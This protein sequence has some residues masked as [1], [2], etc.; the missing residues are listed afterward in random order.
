MSSPFCTIA[1]LLWE[2]GF[3]PLPVM[4]G[5]KIPG[6][7]QGGVWR[8]MRGWTRFCDEVL[9]LY[10]IS[11]WE[12]W[13][14]AGISI[15]H[16]T[17][18]GLDVDTDRK[19]V[20]KAIFNAI[21][22][23]PVKRRGEKGYVAYYRIGEG[24]ENNKAR[25]CWKNGNEILCELL[26]RG[27]HS[28]IPPT[29]HP[30]TGKPYFW[31]TPETLG[32]IGCD[33]LPELKGESLQRLDEELGKLGVK[34]NQSP[35]QMLVRIRPDKSSS[36][37][38]KL[39]NRA[40]EP[41]ALD[42]WWPALKMPKSA[43]RRSGAWEAVPFWRPST[44]GRRT[45]ERNPNLKAAP[46]GIVD[47][48]VGRTH[49]PLDVVMCARGCSP[50]MA[51][52][53]LEQYVRMEVTKLEAEFMPNRRGEDNFVSECPDRSDVPDPVQAV[54]SSFPSGTP[55]SCEQSRPSEKSYHYE[56][57]GDSD[58]KDAEHTSWCMA[59]VFRRAKPRPK[60][61]EI[62][63]LSSA[64][65]ETLLPRDAGPFPITNYRHD[66]PGLL[67][68]IASYLEKAGSTETEAG[69]LAVALPMLGAVMGRLY[70]TSTGLRTNIYAV[71]LGA[72][73]TGKTSLVNP[74]KEIMRLSELGSLIGQDRIASGA[75]L[76]K[77]LVTE[78]RRI[79]FLDEFGH[80]L[81]QIGMPGAGVH[82]RQIIS[83]FTQL[84][85]AARSLYTGT[86][87]ATRAP[88]EIDCP[89]LC[90][91][92]MATPE[93]FW[94]A[95]S[96]LA[97]EDGSIARYLVFPIG[98]TG[99]RDPDC[100]SRPGIVSALEHLAAIIGSRS[101]GHQGNTGLCIAPLS[102]KVETARQSLIKTMDACAEYAERNSIKGGMAILRRVAENAIKIALISAV[103][104]NP[105]KPFI[106]KIDFDIGHAIARWSATHMLINIASHIA[107]NQFERDVN[108]VERFVSQAEKK[109]RIWREIQRKFRRIRK[110]DL[111]DIIE[112]LEKEGS[113][114]VQ[115]D[116]NPQGG[117]PV[118]RIFCT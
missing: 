95:F 48:G 100:R 57:S 27:T 107:D 67:G 105:A 65:F 18:I 26:L 43:S 109:G 37:W 41:A 97:L 20:A 104:R 101:K 77:M 15:V 3:T 24:L 33:E 42:Q 118:K 21:E 14:E 19:D 117:H 38:R 103:G 31:L 58:E 9:P 60:N 23:S 87:Y 64:D 72:S 83:E 7:Y 22:P 74:A 75:G 34:R 115:T 51:K 10:Q 81:Q 39:N 99:S 52:N 76:I 56:K 5:S 69:G 68:Q 86:A 79:C 46:E 98:Y 6:R 28:V 78:P 94:R 12:K 29:L 116:P 36:P 102:E 70:A 53:W 66:C 54:S 59:P 63:G 50:V 8:P 16:G 89:H 13:P 92:G 90:L 80:M 32:D 106:E 1:A 96:S 35:E 49:T 88:V 4:P 108:D 114:R 91:F 17:V 110:R 93:Q 11:Q 85:S 25:L 61:R 47:F 55:H 71:A 113:V 82:A 2:N 111:Q 30:K 40:L 44:S 84:F 112:G 73:G 45:E 62:R